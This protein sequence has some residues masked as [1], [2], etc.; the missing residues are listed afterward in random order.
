MTNGREMSEI[1]AIIISHARS[2]FS[3]KLCVEDIFTWDSL[4]IAIF[5]V[6]AIPFWGLFR[7]RLNWFHGNVRS[8]HGVPACYDTGGLFSS[9]HGYR[10]KWKSL[11]YEQCRNQRR[12][13]CI[14]F[15]R[16][17]MGRVAAPMISES[18]GQTSKRFCFIFRCKFMKLL[19]GANWKGN[20]INFNFS[21]LIYWWGNWFDSFRSCIQ[22]CLQ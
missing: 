17:R 5:I 18:T 3:C 14:F 8:F 16:G 21:F 13:F 1:I 10:A 20:A 15:K 2:S 4:F 11:R 7:P 12:R 6:L 19:Y 22:A 9:Y